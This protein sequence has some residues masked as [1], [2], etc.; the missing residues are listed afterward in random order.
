[1]ASFTHSIVV[2]G[3]RGKRFQITE[4]YNVS[5]PGSEAVNVDKAHTAADLNQW[6]RREGVKVLS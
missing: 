1:M 2:I 6:A 3:A 4:A 5:D